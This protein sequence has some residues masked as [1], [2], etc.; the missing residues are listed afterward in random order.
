MTSRINKYMEANKIDEASNENINKQLINI[1]EHYAEHSA[2][3]KNF[4]RLIPLPFGVLFFILYPVIEYFVLGD[5]QQETNQKNAIDCLYNNYLNKLLLSKLWY[6]TVGMIFG[7][8]AKSI[9][10][11]VIDRHLNICFLPDLRPIVSSVRSTLTTMA[12]KCLKLRDIPLLITSLYLF[13]LIA[14]EYKDQKNSGITCQAR[15]A[16]DSV[17]GCLQ[18]ETNHNLSSN[19][20]ILFAEGF[21]S[22]FCFF[23]TLLLCFQFLNLIAKLGNKVINKNSNSENPHRLFNHANNRRELT[24]FVSENSVEMEEIDESSYSV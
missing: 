18:T 12:L 6:I 10:S 24:S 5:C 8:A 22:A 14:D 13:S 16:I 15:I 17:K 9:E 7:F 19:Y 2:A 20:G 23:S 4:M 1:K 11:Y 21:T 3:F